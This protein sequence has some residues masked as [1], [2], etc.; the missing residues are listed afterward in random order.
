MGLTAVNE[1]LKDAEKCIELKPD[2]AKGYTRKG[3][4]EFFT[5]Q[6]DKALETYQEGLKH[7]PNNED[8]IEVYGKSLMEHRNADTLKRLNETERELKE[9]KKKAYLD[10]AKA[11]EAREKGNELFKEQKYPEAVEQYT[12]SIA[13][14][15]DDHRVYSNRA[16]CYTKLTAFNEA[17][18]D[19][20]KCIELKPDPEI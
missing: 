13:R 11:D 19:A 9:R 1:A 10:P 16:A 3:H 15:P 18:K 14:N 20:E 2:W 8:A 5:K 4:V 12:E 7:D 17:L 6:Y